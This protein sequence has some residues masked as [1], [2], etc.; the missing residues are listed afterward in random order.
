MTRRQQR[1]ILV[2]TTLIALALAT[3]LILS[4]FRKNLVF[5]YTPT[6]VLAGEAPHNRSFRLGGMVEANSLTRAE[7]GITVSFIVT[8]M[9]RGVPVHYRGILPD[10]FKEGKGVVAQGRLDAD[11]RFVAE[12]VLA[13]HDEN[14]MPPDAAYA[15]KKGLA[16][17]VDK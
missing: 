2:V 4:A 8:D 12:E 11:H 13:K 9:A 14:Y 6:Q 16:A 1:L 10:L 7:D 5:F 3:W 17:K 15:L